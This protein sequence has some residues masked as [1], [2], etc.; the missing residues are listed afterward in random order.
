[1]H[2]YVTAH[3]S[4]CCRL[5]GKSSQSPHI[6]FSFSFFLHFFV[7][8]YYLFC[9]CVLLIKPFFFH[10]RSI[11]QV[12]H[13]SWFFSPRSPPMFPSQSSILFFSPRYFHRTN[14][15]FA[16]LAYRDFLLLCWPNFQLLFCFEV[17]FN[18]YLC[19]F[20][21]LYWNS[22]SLFYIS[23]SPPPSSLPLS[24]R[25][26]SSGVVPRLNFPSSP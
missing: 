9:V 24:P 25:P 7:T 18:T 15:L 8:P 3:T 12:T 21:F 20:V 6:L 26:F 4:L 5:G 13:S 14:F 23:P 2:A 19:V 11:Y 1:M 22:S 16:R 17:Q 10:P